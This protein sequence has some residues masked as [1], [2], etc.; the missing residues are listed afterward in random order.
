M[1]I[2]LLLLRNIFQIYEIMFRI[3]YFTSMFKVAHLAPGHYTINFAR[4][5]NLWKYINIYYI[6]WLSK[7]YQYG[8]KSR[9]I[10]GKVLIVCPA[11]LKYL[12]LKIMHLG[13]SQSISLHYTFLRKL[14]VLFIIKWGIYGQVGQIW[15]FGMYCC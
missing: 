4:F 7:Q 2:F 1:F 13:N 3:N 8:N 5:L 15:Y 10:A 11:K 12:I 6:C 9:S 14:Y